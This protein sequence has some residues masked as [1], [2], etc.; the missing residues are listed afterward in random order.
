MGDIIDPH[1]H[2]T[3]GPSDYGKGWERCFEGLASEIG[4]NSKEELDEVVKIN[5]A[6][7]VTKAGIICQDNSR[8]FDFR[9]TI[10]YGQEVIDQ[11]PD[12]WYGTVGVTPVNKYWELDRKNLDLFKY[13]IDSLGFK[14]MMTA[15]TYERF[16]AD[17]RRAYPFYEAALERD[18]PIMF[19]NSSMTK[20][21]V[22]APLEFGDPRHI[23]K[24]GIDYPDLRMCIEHMGFPWENVTLGMME[25]NPNLY[26]EISSLWDRPYLTTWNLVIAKEYGYQYLR[27][28]KTPYKYD[29]GLPDEDY[30]QDRV[31]SRVMYGSDF[32]GTY[33]L[34][35]PGGFHIRGDFA[36]YVNF[37]KRDINAVAEKTGWPKFT[38]KEIDGILG[39]NAKNFIKNL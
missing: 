33:D 37:V 13:A 9:S 24:V 27:S 21:P 19:H 36:K 38:Q 17:D 7:G 8:I 31:L 10:E 39:D 12:F 15:P 26:T 5:K 35:K 34:T 14:C 29:E 32:Y 22:L 20:P 23:D 6:L 28:T 4:T 3:K 1:V 11:Y 18:I 2:L 30:V 16:Q 25:K